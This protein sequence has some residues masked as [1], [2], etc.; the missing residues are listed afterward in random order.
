MEARPSP[1]R[2]P[3]FLFLCPSIK[4]IWLVLTASPSLLSSSPDDIGSC[5]YILLSGSVFIKESMFLPRSRWVLRLLNTDCSFIS[6][7]FRAP[8]ER[9]HRGD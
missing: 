8:S 2:Y 7:P 4:N 9:S 6:S 5:W 3:V 1:S